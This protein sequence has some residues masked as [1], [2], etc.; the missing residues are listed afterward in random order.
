MFDFKPQPNICTSFMSLVFFIHFHID[1]RK[2]RN[3]LN[4]VFIS[5]GFDSLVDYESSDES[6]LPKREKIL[7]S[8]KY[9]MIYFKIQFL[10][11]SH[12]IIEKNNSN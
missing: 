10:F 11:D 5:F 8:N 1:S 9:L 7:L 4:E 6:Q 12:D 2:K 3:D